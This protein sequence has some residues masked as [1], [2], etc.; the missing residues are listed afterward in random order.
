MSQDALEPGATEVVRAATRITV[1]WLGNVNTVADPSQ[2][3]EAFGLILESLKDVGD[4]Q[5]AYAKDARAASA[6]TVAL[7]PADPAHIVSLIDGKP[8]K[9][10]RRHLAVRG[11]SPEEYRQRFGLDPSYPMVSCGYSEQRRQIA[12]RSGLG[13][14]PR[15]ARRMRAAADQN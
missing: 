13:T 1:A 6:R 9:A 8:Y 7:T 3:T 4:H 12:K 2:V 14:L 11:L 5:S 10:L 15:K